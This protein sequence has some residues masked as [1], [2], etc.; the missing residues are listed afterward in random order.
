MQAV[1]GLSADL[2]I[3]VPGVLTL[4]IVVPSVLTLRFTGNDDT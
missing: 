4:R 3:V 2:M 1:R